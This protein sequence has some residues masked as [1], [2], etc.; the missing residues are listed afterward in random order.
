MS[1]AEHNFSGALATWK[2][3]KLQELQKTLDA[4]GIEIVDNQKES[5][6]GRKQL[7]D[8]TKEFKKIPD[9]EKLNSFKGLLK[10]YQTEIDNLTKRS[11]VSENAFLNVY[12]VLAEAPDPYPLLEAAV[13]QTVKATEAH[14]LEAEVSRLRAE[15]TELRQSS[16]A[17]D[18]SK[19][20]VEQLETRMDELVAQKESEINAAYDERMR[21]YE[22]REQ[23]LHRQVALYRDQV[24]DLRLSNESNQ[25][26]LFDHSQR[27]DQE[28]ISRL[29]EADMIMVDLE[30]AN[31]R[32]VTVEQRNEA[33]RGE[34]EALRIGSESSERVRSL[35]TRLAELE[36]EYT[37][38]ES[39]V[40]VAR[41]AAARSEERI[42]E[43][44]READ[45]ARAE[46][47][48][49]KTKLK[50]YADY[51]EVKRELEIL[52]YVEFAGLDPDD[53]WSSPDED[54]DGVHLPNPNA[55]K[56]NAQ[57]GKSLEVLLATKNKRILEELTRFRILH[58]SLEASLKSTQDELADTH[59]ELVK[60]QAL[61]EKLETDLLALNTNNGSGPREE[62]GENGESGIS[63]LGLEFGLRTKDAAG[64]STT[65]STPIPFTSSADTSILPIVTSQRDRF[66]QRNAELEE[67]LRK[68]YHTISELRTEIKS[69]QSDNLKLY[70]KVRYMQSY[71]EQGSVSQLD[72]LPPSSSSAFNGSGNVSGTGNG[73]DELGKWRTRYEE[74]MNPFE[75]FRGR[76]ATRAYE[77]LNPVERGVL[78]LTRGIIGNRR[79][80]TAFIFYAAALH[81]LVVVTVYECAWSSGQLQVQPGPY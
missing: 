72:P 51:D 37:R 60:Q 45:S 78:V 61:C 74:A 71:R 14:A 11:K 20:R 47:E 67:E 17:F 57:H 31:S 69:L 79:A 1:A 52:K 7:A 38:L 54:E 68:H 3:I 55:D 62:S 26:K 24:R 15:N 80:R 5:I 21:N 76:E 59:A 40:D 70:E 4:Q 12:K 9:D 81:L 23:D 33:L 41:S 19:R 27:Q 13:D 63:G 36:S 75:A 77:A 25:A 35:T 22:E 46:V 53:D 44:A 39:T 18:A 56:A 8:R 58:T 65:R 48:A 49:L 6:L 43:K 16:S 66:R 29:A 73:R 32:V 50:T 2:D 10:A 42:S 34:I 28:V 30:R 64:P